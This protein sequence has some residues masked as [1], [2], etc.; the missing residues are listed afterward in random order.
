[1]GSHE[2]FRLKEKA[3]RLLAKWRLAGPD[4][5]AISD[6]LYQA[7]KETAEEARA[8]RCCEETPLRACEACG[9]LVCEGCLDLHIVDEEEVETCSDCGPP[10]V[11][12]RGAVRRGR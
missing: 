2:E 7:L 3:R 10:P 11:V 1:M 12:A 9:D 6:A 4:A 8:C 5:T